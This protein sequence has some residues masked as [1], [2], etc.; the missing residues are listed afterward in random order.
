M[1]REGCIERSFGIMEESAISRVPPS[2][3]TKMVRLKLKIAKN[4]KILGV[5]KSLLLT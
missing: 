2:S 3:I 5:A 4:I 1:E